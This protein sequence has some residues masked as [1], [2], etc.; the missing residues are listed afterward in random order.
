MTKLLTKQS[1]SWALYDWANSAYATIVMA[2]FFQ[3]LFSNYWYTDNGNT[4]TPLG[5]ANAIGSLVIVLIA[6]ILGAIADRGGLKKNLLFIFAVTGILFTF[7]LYF[8]GE[9]QWLLALSIYVLA[10]IGFAGANVF[11]DAMLVDVAHKDKIDLTSALGF[12]LGYLAGGITLI[13]AALFTQKMEWF[14]FTSIQQAQ[15]ATFIMVAIWWLLFTIPILINVKEQKTV[16]TVPLNRAIKEGFQQ[17]A[18]T[19]REIRQLKTVFLFLAAYW[20]Y[21]DGV[22]TIIRMA[23]DYGKRLNFDD[24]N[25]MY[26][27]LITQ[28]IGFPAALLYGKLGERIGAKRA[29]L[30]AI[31]VYIGV[32]IYGYRMDNVSEFYVLAFVVGLVQGGIQS[33]S[34][35]FYI[36]LIP[37]NKMT[38]FFGFYNMLGKLAAVLGPL[39]MALVSQMTGSPRLAILSIAILFILG[40]GLLV[41][42]K[43][44]KAP[45]II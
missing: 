33:L 18:T 7:T 37:A 19:F 44:E 38:E 32:T 30:I 17:L 11:Y 26:A 43:P 6:P 12:S 16:T 9:G 40:G 39:L 35:S 28:F 22:D 3:L 2:V 4:T 27:F 34:R 21:I 8:I 29:I 13:I 23:I 10:G 5:I 15:L 20:L 14:G 36:R 1:L 41:F 42:V 24:T 25:L 31:G 45:T